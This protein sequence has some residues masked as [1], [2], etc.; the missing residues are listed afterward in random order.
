MKVVGNR[1]R[2]LGLDKES[3][4]VIMGGPVQLGPKK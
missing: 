3:L 2:V 4:E 1:D